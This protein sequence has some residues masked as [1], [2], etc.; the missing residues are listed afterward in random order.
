MTKFFS[1]ICALTIVLSASAAQQATDVTIGSY[2]TYHQFTYDE[3]TLNGDYASFDFFILFGDDASHLQAGKTYTLDDIY[4]DSVS[5]K[6]YGSIYYNGSW[7]DGLKAFSFLKTIDEDGLV[8]FV[9]S[10]TDSLDASFTFHYDQAPVVPTG[11]TVTYFINDNVDMCYYSYYHM[12]TVDA[13]DRVYGFALEIF[14][15]DATPLLGTF[16]SDDFDFNYTYAKEYISGDQNKIFARSATANIYV[17][18][19]TTFV[20]VAIIGEDGRLYKLSAI[21]AD[22][23]AIQ[24]IDENTDAAAKATKRLENGQ[25]F[26]LRNDKTYTV[27]GQEVK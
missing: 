16:T 9:G 27:T 19:D 4:V 10:A 1:L 22:S 11:D 15:N 23:N 6:Q 21:S 13:D 25:L 17:Q 24:H 5:G 20:D 7:H 2:S 12:W 3:L 14:A 8:H 18:G 26:I